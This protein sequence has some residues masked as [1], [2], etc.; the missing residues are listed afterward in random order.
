[1]AA[2]RCSSFGL[3]RR[4]LLVLLVTAGGALTLIVPAIWLR[5]SE[6]GI[7]QR[8]ILLGQ[9]VPLTGPSGQ[10]GQAFVAGS[11]AY[12][13]L[14]NSQGGVYGRRIA[15][16]VLDD[17]Y[18]PVK[19]ARNVRDLIRSQKVYAL[20]G[21][22]GV[23]G[24][25][26]ALP[27]MRSQ[28]V[29]LVAPVSGAQLIRNPTDPLIFNIRASYY[30]EAERLV[31]YLARYGFRDV[32]VFYQNDGYGRDGLRGVELALA[33]RRMKLVKT[34]TV[35]RNSLE[36]AV[37]A[38][39]IHD[40]K[41]DA[42][43]MISTYGTVASFVRNIKSLGSEAQLM[44]VS[45]VGSLPLAKALGPLGR[46]IGIT[47]VVPFPWDA[48]KPIVHEY[49]SIL[50]RSDPRLRFSFY[51]LEGFLAAKTTVEAL[52]RAGPNP[53]R[54]SL[55]RGLES[56]SNVDFGGFKLSFSPANHNGSDFVQLTFMMG[57]GAN[58]IH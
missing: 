13:D 17:Q 25:Q 31:A 22:I 7:N 39:Q 53:T 36:T 18:D 8:T 3:V 58:F 41:P 10:L 15:V 6:A 33:R 11:L 24:I 43:V 4:R 45:F 30:Q 47:Q 38:R 2:I 44:S 50:R 21:L 12:F 32:A 52:R 14:V 49:Q 56:M 57:G 48:T 51:S 23:P 28:G 19:T 29:P 9:S 42:V 37:A 26:A 46:N 40:A 5:A 35:Q 20:F 16:Q 55:R 34:A 54:A 27:E 1:M